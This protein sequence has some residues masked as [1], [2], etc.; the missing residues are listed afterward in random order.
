MAKKPGEIDINIKA[1]ELGLSFENLSSTLESQFNQAISDVAH[2]VH[3]NI[4]AK[5]SRG[6]AAT[7]QDYLKD[8]TF[9][10]VGENAY[11][12]GLS[13]DW[14]NKLEDGYPGY[15]LRD[16]L[17]KSS[18]TVQVGSRAGQKWVQEGVK[19]QKYAHV[20]L[21]HRPFSKE[22][23]S[24]NLAESIKKLQ[25]R[26]QKGRMQNITRTFKDASGKP[27]SGKVATIGKAEIG[28]V[29]V[30]DLDG[31]VKY[32]KVYKNKSG[33]ETT[34]SVYMTY[35][36]ISELGGGWQHPGWSGLKAFPEAEMLA[37]KAIEDILK[38]FLG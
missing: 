22:A 4:V 31:L 16:R 3:A 13:G 33:K 25:A 18:K 38:S 30:K 32:Q 8:L 35:R 10:K 24:G 2:A 26:N 29:H 15:D 19:G 7:R 6:L 5:A 12:I 17:L 37:E 36:T 28:N 14:A 21:E 27:L 9:D 23:K 34:Q 11:V 20:P 1:E